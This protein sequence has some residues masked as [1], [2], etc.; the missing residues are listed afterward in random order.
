MNLLD[1]FPTLESDAAAL[2]HPEALAIYV[3]MEDVVYKLGKLALRI[4]PDYD[5]G[6]TF[7]LLGR[8]NVRAYCPCCGNKRNMTPQQYRIYL[9]LLMEFTGTKEPN[10][11]PELICPPCAFDPRRAVL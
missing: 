3:G 6:K 8:E 4:E 1:C 11:L 2:T 10:W 7:Y 5:S 9:V